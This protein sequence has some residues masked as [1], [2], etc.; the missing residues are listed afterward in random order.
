MNRQEM[1]R[2]LALVGMSLQ[3][4][5]RL[6]LYVIKQDGSVVFRGDRQEAIDF[7]RIIRSTYNRALR[8]SKR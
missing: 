6:K 1:R 4:F 5:T 7:V 2:V 3:T 8:D